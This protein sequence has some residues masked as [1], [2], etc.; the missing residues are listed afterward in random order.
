MALYKNSDTV[1][2]KGMYACMNLFPAVWPLRNYF[3]FLIPVSKTGS[4]L[5]EAKLTSKSLRKGSTEC[6]KD[7]WPPVEQMTSRMGARAET[8]SRNIAVMAEIESST[9]TSYSSPIAWT[10]F[11]PFGCKQTT[12]SFYFRFSKPQ[13]VFRR[14]CGCPNRIA[15]SLLSARSSYGRQ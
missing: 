14:Q 10:Y 11:Q 7:V 9:P 8:V 3:R 15:T 2:L 6:T 1:K 5:S 13:V 12:S 4:L